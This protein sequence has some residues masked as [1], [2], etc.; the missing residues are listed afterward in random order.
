MDGEGDIKTEGEAIPSPEPGMSLTPPVFDPQGLI[1]PPT[2]SATGKLT[3]S[4]LSEQVQ[5][6]IGVT[7]TYDLELRENVQKVRVQ[8]KQ[9]IDEMYETFQKSKI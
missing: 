4:E 2:Y 3:I 7:T 1:K 9:F 8:M 5:T 6:F